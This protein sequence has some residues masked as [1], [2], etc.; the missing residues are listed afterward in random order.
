[1]S[2]EIGLREAMEDLLREQGINLKDV[3]DMMDEE[4]TSALQSISKISDLTEEQLSAVEKS[5]SY[6]Q[7]NLLAFAIYALYLSNIPGLYKGMRLVP[8][9]EEVIAG[10]RVTFRGLSAV[11]GALGMSIRAT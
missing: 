6:R 1:M 8:S 11:A 2:D 10:Q 4:R 5:L 7:I 3:L 9:R